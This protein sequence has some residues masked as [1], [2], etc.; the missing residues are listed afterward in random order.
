MGFHELDL[1]AQLGEDIN[2]AVDCDKRQMMG[3][4]RAGWLNRRLSRWTVE[5]DGEH[6]STFKKPKHPWRWVLAIIIAILLFL[7]LR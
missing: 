6:L 2:L 1:V 3:V 4:E 5:D 7:A